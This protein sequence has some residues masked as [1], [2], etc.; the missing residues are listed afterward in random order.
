VR[1]R[2]AVS[3]SS[4]I[5]SEETRER[6]TE[7]ERHRERETKRERVSEEIMTRMLRGREA[8][9]RGLCVRVCVCVRERGRESR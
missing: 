8:L 6:D 5:S 4:L 1:E 2:E 9:S 7:R 3:Q